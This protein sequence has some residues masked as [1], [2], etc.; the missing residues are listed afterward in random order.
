[1][2]IHGVAGSSVAQLVEFLDHNPN[3]ADSNLSGAN[4]GIIPDL[5]VA[6]RSFPQANFR[7][8]SYFSTSL[9]INSSEISA[10]TRGKNWE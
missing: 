5:A 2:S 3:V 10:C 6:A 4:L 1:M 9:Q 7:N 8:P